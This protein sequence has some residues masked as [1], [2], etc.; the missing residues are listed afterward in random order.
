[1]SNRVSIDGCIEAS[2]E[3][4]LT[5][6]LACDRPAPELPREGPPSSRHP[7]LQAP[8]VTR[9]WPAEPP[10][11]SILPT[12]LPLLVLA[13][14]CL[15]AALVIIP[16]VD[17]RGGILLAALLVWGC[18]AALLETASR[19][20]AT[21]EDR[22]LARAIWD[23][24]GGEPPER[25][26]ERLRRVDLQGRPRLHRDL[27]VRCLERSAVSHVQERVLRREAGRLL[28]RARDGLRKEMR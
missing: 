28:D 17:D 23:L 5:P 15:C 13:A 26:V 7:P 3:S 6:E 8:D 12:D 10:R 11:R 9:E 25:I 22:A 24:G 21:P 2:Q 20:T 14:A 27:A 16:R 4:I 1:M 18:A 19:W